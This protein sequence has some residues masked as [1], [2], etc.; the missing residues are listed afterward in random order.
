[1][2]TKLFLL[3]LITIFTITSCGDD[4]DEPNSQTNNGEL[5][6]DPYFKYVGL[7]FV[8][9]QNDF[10]VP[11]EYNGNN[12]YLNNQWIYNY[13][14]NVIFWVTDEKPCSTVTL[15]M[16]DEK[17]ASFEHFKI[18]TNEALLSL[19]EPKSTAFLH[20]VEGGH[21]ILFQITTPHKKGAYNETINFA[22]KNN[23][24]KIGNSCEMIWEKNG[25]NIKYR[26][27][28]ELSSIYHQFSIY[29][30]K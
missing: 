11:L 1:M 25:Y 22:E 13:L 2:K 15:R 3:I 26:F 28:S 5:S 14:F 8:E 6:I 17:S 12:Y 4:K 29:I 30:T 16:K 21:D 23:V 27:S 20:E 7:S 9:I 24:S 18:F 19:G 10:S